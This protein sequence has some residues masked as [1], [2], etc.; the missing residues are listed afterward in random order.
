MKNTRCIAILPILFLWGCASIGAAGR[1]APPSGNTTYYCWKETLGT[2]SDALVCNWETSRTD[3]CRLRNTS[4]LA[5]DTIASG[6]VD[7]GRCDNGQWL[8]KVTTR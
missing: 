1:D 4:M 8:L 6:P 2:R 3:A 5:R 7:A